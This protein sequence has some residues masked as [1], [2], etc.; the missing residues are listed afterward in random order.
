VKL[1]HK[2]ASEKRFDFDFFYLP[3]RNEE[4]KRGVKSEKFGPDFQ[5]DALAPKERDYLAK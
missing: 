5:F 1:K 2:R 4:A 3:Q